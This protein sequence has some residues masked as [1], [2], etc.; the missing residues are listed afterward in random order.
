MPPLLKGP[1]F[2]YDNNISK[3]NTNIKYLIW[4]IKPLIE[5]LLDLKVIIIWT[6]KVNILLILITYNFNNKIVVTA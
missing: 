3:Y 2:T 6:N 1:A 4:Y 5:D